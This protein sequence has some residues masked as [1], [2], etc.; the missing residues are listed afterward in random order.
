MM[1]VLAAG[2]RAGRELEGLQGGEQ[3]GGEAGG[4]GSLQGNTPLP[5]T[6]GRLAR[7]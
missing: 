5:S 2:E 6:L 1:R 3:G 7:D 4:R